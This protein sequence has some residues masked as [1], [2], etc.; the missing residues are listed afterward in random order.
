MKRNTLN[1]IV[2]FVGLLL[3]WGLLVTG[4]LIKYILPPG[5]GHFLA[6]SGMTRHDWGEIHF[7]MAVGVCVVVFLHVLLHWQWVCA[8]TRKLV[9]GSGDGEYVGRKGWRAVWGVVLV[10]ILT[11][12]AVGL[13]VAA[14]AAITEIEGGVEEHIEELRGRGQG[15]GSGRGE[16]RQIGEHLDRT[17]QADERRGQGPRGGVGGGEGRRGGGRGSSQ[18]TG[19]GRLTD[20][21]EHGGE[22]IR[23]SMTLRQVAEIKGVSVNDLKSALGLPANVPPDERL[24]RL[25][26]QYGFSVADVRDT[27]VQSERPEAG[28]GPR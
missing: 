2:D 21:A 9:A 10:M 8:T 4:L 24:G 23:G 28:E 1:Y 26:R 7:W 15:Q 13:L 11:G 25:A 14:N 20:D 12:A 16:R 17:P 22:H 18:G 27:Q 5:S 6:V 3:M 19:R